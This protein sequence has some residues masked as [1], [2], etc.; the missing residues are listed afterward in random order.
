MKRGSISQQTF[1][2]FEIIL[3]L[4]VAGIFIYT[5]TNITEFSNVDTTFAERDLDLLTATVLSAPGD[6]TY[7]YQLSGKMEVES[8]TPFDLNKDLTSTKDPYN[9]TLT[10]DSHK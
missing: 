8:T 7:Q 2:A 10:K 4:V 9:I 1:F 3:G 6:I 5:A